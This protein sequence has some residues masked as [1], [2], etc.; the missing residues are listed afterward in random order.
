[1]AAICENCGFTPTSGDE[2][3]KDNDGEDSSSIPGISSSTS[4]HPSSINVPEYYQEFK[5]FMETA[6]SAM[7]KAYPV[8][9]RSRNPRVGVLLLSFEEDD[10]GVADEIAPLQEVF[11]KKYR[12][13]TEAWQIPSKLPRSALSSKLNA[14]I[15]KYCKDDREPYDALPLLIIYYGGH[16]AQPPAGDNSCLWSG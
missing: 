16:A 15:D 14:F 11:E 4:T 3:H 5:D 8:H 1:M 12:Y 10:L 13:E 6:N 7:M 9:R 2:N